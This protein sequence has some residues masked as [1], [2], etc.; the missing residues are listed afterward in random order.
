MASGIPPRWA[1]EWGEDRHGVFAGFRVGDVRHR[2][3]YIP[4]GVFM[5]GSPEDEAGRFP[6]ETQHEVELTKGFWLGATPCTQALWEAVTG[7]NPSRFKTPDRPV[8]NVSW[9]D[10]VEFFKKLNANVSKLNAAFPTEAQWEYACRAGTRAATYAGNLEILGRNI[11]PL[12]HGI[13]WYGGNCGVDFELEN[14]W[15]TTDDSWKEKQFEFKTGGSHRVGL[16][17][18]NPWGLHDMLGNVLEWCADWYG[19]YPKAR[20]IDP[21]GPTTGASRVYRGGSWSSDARYVRAARRSDGDPVARGERLG[22]RLARG[23]ED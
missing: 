12:L 2:M 10:C 13:A 18:P 6:N 11:A 17:R 19:D 8:E 1:T 20:T 23:Q 22:F 5:M 16:K 4:P 9:N 3:R 15:N 7:E 21:N 14:G